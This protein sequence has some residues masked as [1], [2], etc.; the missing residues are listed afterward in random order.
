MSVDQKTIAVYNEKAADYA[1]RFDTNA[2]PGA[3]LRR[4]IEALPSGGDVLDLGCGTAGASRHMMAAGLNVD[5]MDASAEMI[6]V[7]AEVNGVTAR[8]GTFDDLDAVDAYDG[9]WAN[10]SLLHAPREKLPLH[11]AAIVRALRAGGVFHIGMKTG[12]GT[13]RDHLERKYTFVSETELR[14]LLTDAVLEIAAQDVG[15]EVG[16]AGT[17]DWWIVVMAVKPSA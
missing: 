7:A 15:H 14:D 17:D 5:A 1:A 6:R 10:F 8:Q 11:L 16:L 12:A 13:T 4:F 9:V 3:H 2:K